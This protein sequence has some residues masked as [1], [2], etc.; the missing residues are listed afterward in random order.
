MTIIVDDNQL[1]PWRL[2][3]N[4]IGNDIYEM[5]DILTPAPVVG[6]ILYDKRDGCNYMVIITIYYTV[7]K[8]FTKNMLC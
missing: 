3:D 7:D 8:I 6:R 5:L 4:I 2:Y 1:T